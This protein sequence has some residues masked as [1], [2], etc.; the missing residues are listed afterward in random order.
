MRIAFDAVAAWH[1]RRKGY[2]PQEWL[3]LLRNYDSGIAADGRHMRQ[4]RQRPDASPPGQ[5]FSRLTLRI[6]DRGDADVT[7]DAVPLDGASSYLV[8]ED[9][10]GVRTAQ[11][12]AAIMLPDIL[13][14]S[15]PGSPIG[16]VADHPALA[17]CIVTEAHRMAFPSGDATRTCI[18]FDPPVEM[19]ELPY[20]LQ[21]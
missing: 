21:P 2:E 12:L 17:G 1:L 15:L 5:W 10:R 20:D 6:Y 11:L 4:W 18:M 16:T 19:V 7:F 13:I 9:R 8:T 14:A 3:T